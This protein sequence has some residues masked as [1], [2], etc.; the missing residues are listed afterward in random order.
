M[1][2][3]LAAPL[4]PGTLLD[5]MYLPL[6]AFFRGY[7]VV[8]EETA[9]AYDTPTTLDVEFRRKVRTLAGVYQ[10]IGMFPQL[11]FPWSNR[12]WIH[13]MSHKFGRLLLPFALVAL[14]LGS[15]GLPDPF[16]GFVLAGQAGFY[17]LG[18]A[19]CWISEQSAL[20]RL[21]SAVRTSISLSAAA[22]WA[23][24]IFFRPSM[25]FWTGP[26]G[27]YVSVQDRAEGR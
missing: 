22:L 7:R 12:M 6:G 19:D 4:P 25:S 18:V 17:A 23:V 3:T 2:A 26:T 21:S 8:M 5:D 13:F 16:R 10:V 20:K 1:R 11:L 27:A 9:L 15:F 24:S 14:A